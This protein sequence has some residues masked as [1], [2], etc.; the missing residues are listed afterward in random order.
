M[1]TRSIPRTNYSCIPKSSSSRATCDRFAHAAAASTADT[2]RLLLL[3]EAANGKKRGKSRRRSCISPSSA[4]E[5]KEF[6]RAAASLGPTFYLEA[7]WFWRNLYACVRGSARDARRRDISLDAAAARHSDGL[8]DVCAMMGW[9]FLRAAT[10]MLRAFSE[11]RLSIERA[12][13]W[14][15]ARFEK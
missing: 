3:R 4:R 8:W 6:I 14:L 2:T 13:S 12:F 15:F 11:R 10:G 1:R 5:G 7:N 9:T